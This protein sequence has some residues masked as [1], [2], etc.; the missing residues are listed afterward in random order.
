MGLAS[1]S[2]IRLKTRMPRR[3]GGFQQRLAGSAPPSRGR[4]RTP[5]RYDL[6]DSLALSGHLLDWAYGK[7]SAPI[8]R[9]HA[10]HMVAD[11]RR[12]G[13]RPDPIVTLI[14][15]IGG[16]GTGCQNAHRDLLK[17]LCKAGMAFDGMISRVGVT[18]SFSAFIKPHVLLHVLSSVAPDRFA[19]S[20]GA[21]TELTFK[22]WSGLRM[23]SEGQ[24]L[25]GESVYLRG[26][27]PSDLIHT[28]PMTLFEDAAPYAVNKSV[29]TIFIC[30][31]L[32]LGAERDCKFLVAGDDTITGTRPS[33]NDGGWR[34]FLD[35]LHALATGVGP[36]GP[37]C[38]GTIEYK[39][40]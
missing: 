18:E 26:R 13:R 37:F 24:T 7:N 2:R 17:A 36:V 22:F 1:E 40:L 35:S 5:I 12:K 15:T 11:E 4:S 3:R 39:L 27:L 33:C 14:A 16:K 32:G 6:G 10:R 29:D 30:S 23:S 21:D 9:R 31:L 25:W 20:F 8:L 38:E 34:M 19:R 28:L